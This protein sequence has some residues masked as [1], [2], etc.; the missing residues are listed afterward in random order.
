MPR[1]ILRR[2]S[3]YL[4]FV[5]VLCLSQFGI[6]A[7]KT[8]RTNQYIQLNEDAVQETNFEYFIS[9]KDTLLH[10]K[11][12]TLLFEYHPDST[13][14]VQKLH[15]NY[16]NGKADGDYYLERTSF[17]TSNSFPSYKNFR[18]LQSI[19]GKAIYAL[20]NYKQGIR[21]GVWHL[22]EV[23][24][25]ERKL[26]TISTITIRFDNKGRWHGPI[27][28]KQKDF[29]C[30]GT[31]K[32]GV[33][34]GNWEGEYQGNKFSYQFED[35]FLQ[36]VQVQNETMRI[37]N[38]QETYESY[39]LNQVMVTYIAKNKFGKSKLDTLNKTI[40][41]QINQFVTYF[42]PEEK[43]I[44]TH[45]SN[46]TFDFPI[47]HL[48]TYPFNEET[49]IK[50]N[51]F[52]LQH[53]RIFNKVDS[54]INQ[55]DLILSC[56]DNQEIAESMAAFKLVRS[57]LAVY[58]PLFE[59]I[60]SKIVQ[61]LNWEKLSREFITEA[62]LIFE[63]QYDCLSETRIYKINQQDY[64]ESLTFIENLALQLNYI[65]SIYSFHHEHIQSELA[66]ARH[67]EELSK[68]QQKFAQNSIKID[69]LIETVQLA[70]N[71]YHRTYVQGFKN[72]NDLL[73]QRFKEAL[74]NEDMDKAQD[75]NKQLKELI[76]LL[77]QTDKWIKT[78]E[79]IGDKYRYM[80]LDPNTFQERVEFLY[81]QIYRAY[82]RKLMPFVLNQLS[83]NFNH[84]NEFMTAFDNIAILQQRMINLLDENP[85]ALNRKVKSRDNVDKLM[86]K[87]NLI[88]N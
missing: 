26:D 61:H 78:H 5:A 16:V 39:S 64:N 46:F 82:E 87:M 76:L 84:V 88:F 59:T 43:L 54:M 30:N 50:L 15:L 24:I 8:T 67:S 12:E 65:D 55:P 33:I 38:N 47:I 80:Y 44:P 40:A 3:M 73:I 58:S 37:A 57:R 81:E 27:Q 14:F 86:E 22:H 72:F 10:N 52:A 79:F 21:T 66:E 20:G 17:E 25:D 45:D 31:F 70:N 74:A 9:K 69:S 62:N 36:A 6:F 53:E 28:F 41:S 68:I 18:V 23:L 48:P 83:F 13:S 4:N 35:G 71:E 60:H 77:E 32:E 1:L 42:A 63:K 56:R 49:K 75:I 29:Q 11:Y 51:N 7:Q 19:K 85:R 2:F 34:D